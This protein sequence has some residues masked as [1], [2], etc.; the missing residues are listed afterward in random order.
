MAGAL[1]K[2]SSL[3]DRKA[4]RGGLEVSARQWVPAVEPVRVHVAPSRSFTSI[5]PLEPK[6]PKIGESVLL[7]E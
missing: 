5:N 1:H 6:H 2:Q 3:E 7:G 4:F